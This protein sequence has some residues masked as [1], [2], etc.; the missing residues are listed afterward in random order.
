MFGSK[1]DHAWEYYGKTD[2]YFGVLTASAFKTDQL[3]DDSKREFF[4]TGEDYVRSLFESIDRHFDS[5]FRPRR[6]L[7]FGCGVGRLAI[8]FAQRSSEVVA[9]D[10][11]A[12]MLLTAEQNAK[13]YGLPN[14]T[15]VK[16]DDTLSRVSGTFDFVHSFIVFQHIPTPRGYVLFER[17]ID[18]LREDGIG[19]L[20]FT[21]SYASPVS[22]RRRFLT[23]VL[24]QV[25]AA[26]M[27]RNFLGGRPLREPLMQMNEYDMN[28]LLLILARRGCHDV[29]VRFSETS[30]HGREF[31]G[32]T[33]V[34]RKRPL[35]IRAH[36]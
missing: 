6:A 15:F 28:H 4:A 25:P 33:L 2:P 11:S 35:D 7:D 23:R 10:V 34:F 17:L 30:V 16:G 13:A 9:V 24:H 29:H 14:L 36:A 8:P 3:T 21:F 31:Y 20:H 19:A 22:M 5:E 32:A 18:L 26:N 1:T 12:S 27:V